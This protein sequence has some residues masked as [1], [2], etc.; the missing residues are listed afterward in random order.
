[1]QIAVSAEPLVPEPWL[2]RLYQ[3]QSQV[4]A[5]VSFLGLV[6]DINQQAAV[7]GLWI[8]HYPGMTERCLEQL[9]EQAKA[10]WAVQDLVLIH[11]VGA[12]QPNEPIVLVAVSSAHRADA[13]AACEFLIDR[14]KTAAPFWKKEQRGEQAVWLDA[15]DSDTERAQRW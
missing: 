5:V 3:G 14:L 4:G 12:L 10:R 2:Q 8:E 7:S 9:A 6:R 1:M 13:F 15:R 11:R